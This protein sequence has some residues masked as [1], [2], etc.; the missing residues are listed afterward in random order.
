MLTTVPVVK[1]NT[2]EAMGKDQHTSHLILQ[3]R[4]LDQPSGQV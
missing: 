1:L 3:V 4:R 2:Y